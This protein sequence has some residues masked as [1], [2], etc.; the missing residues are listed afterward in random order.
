MKSRFL[1][2]PFA[3]FFFACNKTSDLNDQ[4]IVYNT[5]IQPDEMQIGDNDPSSGEGLGSGAGNVTSGNMSLGDPLSVFQWHLENSGQTTFSNG[6]GTM[7]EDI[8]INLS[9]PYLGAGVLVAVSDNGV[10]VNHEDLSFNALDGTHKNYFLGAPIWETR[11]LR[12]V[13]MLTVQLSL[14]LFWRL[15]KMVRVGEVFLQVHR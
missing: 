12:E 9:S 4:K 15:R 6:S 8:G 13:M 11:F 1:L 10:Q 14:A 7:G 3:I 2:L 5:P